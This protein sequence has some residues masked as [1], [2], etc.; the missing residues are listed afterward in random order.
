MRTYMTRRSY[1]RTMRDLDDNTLWCQFRDAMDLCRIR[2][3]LKEDKGIN[4]AR[5]MWRGY[6]HALVVYTHST[7][8]ERVRRWG[9]RHDRQ[10]PTAVDPWKEMDEVF[11][12]LGKLPPF[13]VPPWWDDLDLYRSHRAALLRKHPDQYEGI[14]QDADDKLASLWPVIAPDDP[15]EYWFYMTPAEKSKLDAGQRILPA[16][17]TDRELV[18]SL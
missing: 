7:V 4:P 3:E 8:Q 6:D 18:Y 15:R 14:W 13:D 16:N 10:D 2:A 1:H 12:A 9:Q 11:R 17:V 5:H